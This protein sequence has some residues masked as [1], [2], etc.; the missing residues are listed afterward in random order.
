[1]G[2]TGSV[3]S[4]WAIAKRHEEGQAQCH[5]QQRNKKSSSVVQR[6]IVPGWDLSEA[7]KFYTAALY[8]VRIFVISGYLIAMARLEH[9][10]PRII[11]Q[12]EVFTL[13]WM[14]PLPPKNANRGPYPGMHLA[15]L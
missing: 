15:D 4:I 3:S 6:S 8:V 2:S 7:L 9:K 10:G 12:Y 13:W 14:L 5:H 11:S 1:M